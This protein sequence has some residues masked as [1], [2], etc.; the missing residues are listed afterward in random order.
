M[1]SRS[2]S[3]ATIRSRRY[4]EMS[5]VVYLPWVPTSV[6][7]SRAESTTR[8]EY[9]PKLRKRTMPKVLVADRDRLAR[10]PFLIEKRLLADEVDLGLERRF[11]PGDRQDPRDDRHVHRRQRVAAGAERVHR[12]A[13]AEED[14]LLV[15]LHDQL[16]PQLDVRRAFRRDAM[17]Q[18]T[19][20]FVEK[21]DD[22]QAN[23]MI[24]VPEIIRVPVEL[25][26]PHSKNSPRSSQRG[27]GRIQPSRSQA[28]PGNALTRGSA[29][30][31]LR[32]AAQPGVEGRDTA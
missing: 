17:H 25:A 22:F 21:V 12:L 31:L 13:V 19:V 29:S 5:S 8:N 7:I 30:A 6:L 27:A 2:V 11:L 20:R 24:G 16:R 9:L 26:A 10:A 14:R 32:I 28:P 18:R 3:R 1:P 15:L 4:D 23:A